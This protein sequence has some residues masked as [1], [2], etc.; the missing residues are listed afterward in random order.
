[1]LTT[2][3]WVNR[4]QRQGRS[5]AYFQRGV[6]ASIVYEDQTERYSEVGSFS[7]GF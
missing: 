1:M 2:H 5:G 6:G 3:V 4:P 7:S